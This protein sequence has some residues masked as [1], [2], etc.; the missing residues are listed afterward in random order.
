M[1]VEEKKHL[2]CSV[3]MIDTMHVNADYCIEILLQGGRKIECV[4][5]ITFDKGDVWSEWKPNEINN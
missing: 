2:V 5:E 3:D 4:G 1:E